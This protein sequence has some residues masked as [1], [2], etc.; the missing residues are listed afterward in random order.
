[1]TL[2]PNPSLHEEIKRYYR[3]RLQQGSC[4]GP[5]ETAEV[6]TPSFGCGEPTSF[7]E[8]KSGEVVLDLGSGAGLDVFRAARAVAPSGHVI[9]VDMTPAMLARA[10]EGAS[11]LGLVNVEF[12]EGLIEELPVEGGSVD[13]IISNCVINL[14]TDKPQV[15]REAYRVLRPGGRLIAS[16]ILRHGPRLT[17]LKPESWCACVDGAEAPESYRAY[18]EDAGF[19]DIDIDMP[20]ADARPGETY[21]ASLRARKTPPR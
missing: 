14:S 20:P 21:S 18:L 13:V 16:D 5:S 6:D 2:N 4:C 17:A 7:A 3:D 12:R 8:L 19:I 10:R 11:R 15:F 9:G 1:M